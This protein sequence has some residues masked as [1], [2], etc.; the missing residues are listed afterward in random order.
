MIISENQDEGHQC[1][2]YSIKKD[3]MVERRYKF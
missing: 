2:Y 1:L 3:E